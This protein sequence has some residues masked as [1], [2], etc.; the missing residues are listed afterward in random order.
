[1]N[2]AIIPL[3]QAIVLRGQRA[4]GRIKSTAAEQR[5][6]WREVGEALNYGRALHPSNQAFGAWCKEEGFDM[7]ARDR[8]DAMWFAAT[9]SSHDA[10][11]SLTHPRAIRQAHRD[12][13][14]PAPS[15]DLDLSAPADERLRHIAAVSPIASKV[16]KLVAHAAGVGQE[17][18][19][20]RKY[21]KKHAEIK[22]MTVEE[23]TSMADK[24]DPISKV[25]PGLREPML[26]YTSAITEFGNVMRAFIARS[27]GVITP[28][29]IL[30]LI[31]NALK[32]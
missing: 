9:P 17:A 15:P 22:G 30:S 3:Q 5:Q 1:M 11:T 24:L 25:A 8:S 28:E 32:A 10:N 14:A 12:S 4:W 7:D 23:M 16:N 6:L 20:A 19:T 27:E 18:E 21:L 2:T 13:S 26:E 29:Y 31:N